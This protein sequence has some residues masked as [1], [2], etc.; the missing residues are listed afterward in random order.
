MCVVLT[1]ILLQSDHVTRKSAILNQKAIGADLRASCSL[2]HAEWRA[3]QG[4]AKG[5]RAADIA[6]AQG[7]S[8]HTIRTPLKRA[9][10]RAGVHSQIAL[11]ARMF[12]AGRQR[13]L[14]RHL[15][16]SRKG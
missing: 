9:M 6:A 11:V 1:R 13:D 16:R 2:T 14:W 15:G 4:L 8:V 3:V 10:A 7:I 12:S 5:K